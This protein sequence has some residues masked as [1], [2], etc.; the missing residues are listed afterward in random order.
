MTPNFQL[1][2]ALADHLRGPPGSNVR[3]RTQLQDRLGLLRPKRKNLKCVG[4]GRAERTY[5]DFTDRVG[6]FDVPRS[7]SSRVL[8]VSLDGQID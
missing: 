4:E 6:S 5:A 3:L 2:Q 7:A 1:V 8:V